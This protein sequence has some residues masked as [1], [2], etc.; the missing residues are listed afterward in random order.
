[1]LHLLRTC[2][3]NESFSPVEGVEVRFSPAGHIIGAASVWIR[4][5]SRSVLFSGDLGRRDDPVMH[6]PAP[7]LAAD[8]IVVEST[9]G[10]RLH[11]YEDPST[12]LAEIVQSTTR[13]NG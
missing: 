2:D 7:P 11:P 9:Y 5:G 13:R 6:P 3:F 10:D 4:D 12:V 1:A 8:H